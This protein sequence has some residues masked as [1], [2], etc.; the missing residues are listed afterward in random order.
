MAGI[1]LDVDITGI[2]K[3]ERAME[4]I[5]P[6][7]TPLIIRR[8]FEAWGYRSQATSAEKYLRGPRPMKLGVITG[9]LVRSVRV[10]RFN[11]RELSISFG[12]D[13]K[14]GP[15]HEFGSPEQGLIARPFI[16]PAGEANLRYVEGEIVDEM[17]RKL[18]PI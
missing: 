5:S 3:V 17:R 12:T 16:R 10:N 14:Y 9:T 13:K 11:E 15:P 2:R 7:H 4:A 18:R 6:E 1:S 8:P